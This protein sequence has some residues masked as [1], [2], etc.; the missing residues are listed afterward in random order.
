G[1]GGG[2]SPQGQPVAHPGWS[3]LDDPDTWA[4]YTQEAA[5]R[6]GM[7]IFHLATGTDPAAV[8]GAGL[9][10]VAPAWEDQFDEPETE[11]F[12]DEDQ[13]AEQA[14]E[15]DQVS[16]GELSEHQRSRLRTFVRDIVKLAPT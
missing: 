6:L 12:E 1:Q 2:G 11:A 8:V 9:T 14:E 3:T 16:T 4:D 13:T 15:E 7:P 5:L 10:G